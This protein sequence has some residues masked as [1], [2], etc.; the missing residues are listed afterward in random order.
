MPIPTESIARAEWWQLYV[1]VI[2]AFHQFRYF[3]FPK[4]LISTNFITTSRP[5][6]KVEVT[7]HRRRAL[8][9]W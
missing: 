2:S 8:T 5:L 7:L 4:P 6:A 9:Q 1:A 3:S